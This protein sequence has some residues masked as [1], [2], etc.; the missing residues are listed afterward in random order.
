MSLAINPA[1]DR[2]CLLL[3]FETFWCDTLSLNRT[4]Y[5]NWDLWNLT[6]TT[7]GRSMIVLEDQRIFVVA[8]CYDPNKE[9]ARLYVYVAN[10]SDP[11]QPVPLGL[12][13]LSIDY[14]WESHIPQ[15]LDDPP[16]PISVHGDSKTMI[17]VMPF[18]DRVY[19]L[20]FEDMLPKL[21]F[22]H[23]SPEQHIEFGH[24]V[25]MLDGESYAVLARS[26]PT[27][28]WAL[29]RIQV[30]HTNEPMEIFTCFL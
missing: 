27:L 21:I 26:L 23:I 7:I 14:P 5:Q 19:I 15:T 8:Y 2:M 22:T 6:G 13:P 17:I 25:A 4:K 18:I 10:F 30:N 29:S 12:V 20:S 3:I 11:S 24:S 28:S 9:V 1:G 16:M